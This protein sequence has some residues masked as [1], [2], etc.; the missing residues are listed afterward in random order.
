M[1]WIRENRAALFLIGAGVIFLA[2]GA[3][4]GEAELVYRKA[5]NLCME[6]I[7]LG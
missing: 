5:I 7:G 1:R 2:L 6:C 3:G 4:R